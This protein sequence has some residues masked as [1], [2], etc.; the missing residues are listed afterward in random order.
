MLQLRQ[1]VNEI[2]KSNVTKA[3]NGTGSSYY[4]SVNK[5]LKAMFPELF[6]KAVLVANTAKFNSCSGARTL[7]YMDLDLMAVELVQ[8]QQ[9]AVA[10]YYKQGTTLSTPFQGR[11]PSANEILF[12]AFWC[13]IGVLETS[14]EVLRKTA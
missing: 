6:E 9:D 11:K 3:N 2:L 7:H 4:R 10:T 13:I 12:T 5:D 1:Q 14:E 8:G